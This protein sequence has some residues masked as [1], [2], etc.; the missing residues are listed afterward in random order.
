LV[1]RR[2]PETRDS[3]SLSAGKTCVLESKGVAK[4]LEVL[5]TRVNPH[6]MCRALF[7]VILRHSLLSPTYN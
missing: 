6:R 4:P 5:P 7:L 3:G 2:E 1:L